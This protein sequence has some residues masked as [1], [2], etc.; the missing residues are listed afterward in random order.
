MDIIELKRKYSII[1]YMHTES[2]SKLKLDKMQF[3]YVYI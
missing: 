3:N 1:V 2:K